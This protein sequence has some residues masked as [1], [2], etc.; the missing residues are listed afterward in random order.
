M[1][2]GSKISQ[3]LLEGSP[4]SEMPEVNCGI[5][6]IKINPESKLLATSGQNPNHLAVY[7]LPTFDPV[8]VGEVISHEN[9]K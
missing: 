2:S 8:C 4:L 5:H 9:Y 1:M 3:P 6:S 7:S